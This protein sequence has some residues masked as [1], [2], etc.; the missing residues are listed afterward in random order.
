M[1]GEMNSW[2]I[3]LEAL[4]D[5]VLDVFKK[6][7]LKLSHIDYEG[8]PN[9]SRGLLEESS[10]AVRLAD[11]MCEH[12]GPDSAVEVAICVLEG[13]NQRDT[14]AQLKQKSQQALGSGTSAEHYRQKYR[15]HVARE[16]HTFKEMDACLGENVTLSS[17]YTKLVVVMNPLGRGEQEHE[18]LGLRERHAEVERE[19]TAFTVTVET[20]FQPDERGQT[21]QIVVLVGGAG[22]GKTVTARK[23]MLDWARGAI[24]AQFDYAFYISCR[25]INLSQEAD[26]LSLLDLISA[27][28]PCGKAPPEAILA[29]P[30]KLLFIIDGFDEL[31]FPCDQPKNKLCSDCGERKPV[32]IILSSLFQKTLLSQS[33][34]LI[35]TRP[36]ALQRL[37]LCLKEERYAEII[38]FSDAEK[39]EY[40][41]KFFRDEEKAIKAITFVKRNDTLF[42]MCLVPIM[43]WT[44][45]TV[46]EQELN[47]GKDLAQTSRTTT[48]L[49]M[50]YLSS[51]IK[52]GSDHLKQDMK[53][54][55]SRLCCMAADGIWKRKI[56]FHEKEIEVYGLNHPILLS[57]FLNESVLR[58]RMK[59]VSVY[60]FLHLSFQ[61]FFAAL[62]YAL[63]DDKETGILGKDIKEVLEKYS[64]YDT[65]WVLVVRFLFGLLNE[66]T[67]E[68]LVERTGCKISPRV[69]ED[70]LKWIQ[71]GQGTTSCS[72][73]VIH[74]LNVFHCLFEIQ[75]ETFVSNALEH[76][77]G[78][79]LKDCLLSQYDQMVLSF[80]V[81]RWTG[82]DS[83]HLEWCS[84]ALE[85]RENEFVP[86]PPY[87]S[88][89]N[90]PRSTSPPASLLCQ[91]LGNPRSKLRTVKLWCCQLTSSIC[92]DLAAVLGTSQSLRELDLGENELG[93]LGLQL[94]CEGLKHPSCQLQTLR[95]VRCQLTSTVCGDLAAVL[96]A[97]QSLRELNL[98]GNLLGDLG[99]QLLCEGLKHPSCQLQTLRLLS[100]KLSSTCYGDL[101]VVL[102]TNQ[103]LRELDLID[104]L[105]DPGLQLLCEELK[106]PSCQLQKL[107]LRWCQL[108]SACCGDLAAVLGTSQSLRELDIQGN[109]LED[110][111]LR[112]LCEGLKHPSCQLQMLR[113]VRCEL[114]SACCGDLATTLS[115]NQ[116]LRELDLGENEL[117]DPG[118]RLLCEGLKHPSC[119]LQ[120]LRLWHCQLTSTVCGDLAAVLGASQSLRELD[121]GENE[122]G[123]LGLQLLCEGLKHPSC[124]LQT[125]R[126]WH[127]QLTS[128]VCGD[129]AAVLGASQSLRELDLGGNELGDLGL[130]LLCE[131][132]KHP[133]CQLQTLRLWHCQ[134]TSTVCGDLAAVLGASQSLREL[135]LGGNELGD[136]GLQLLCEGLKHPSCQLQTLRL[137]SCLLTSACCGYLAMALST[138]LS[139]RDLDLSFNRLE[140]SGV[141]LLCE[142]LK[143]PDWQLQTLRLQGARTPSLKAL[144]IL[145]LQ[146]L[147]DS[148]SFQWK[149]CF[150]K[151]AL[152]LKETLQ[153]PRS[154]ESWTISLV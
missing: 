132:L 95:L 113:V 68:Y 27:C 50:L 135:D 61:E 74:N 78:I 136:L 108:D 20:L 32:E 75:E 120:M 18:V 96:G 79:V 122:L 62:F 137:R 21:P 126:L 88:H 94:L 42:A 84:V 73:G 117:G 130:Q 80:C 121:L 34:L 127:C 118:V 77:T 64:E 2:N 111:G 124:Q 153:R 31:R 51:L 104:D 45:C 12:Y 8:T 83:F 151:K 26:M 134:L 7:K 86:G 29:S 119:Q 10:D 154:V 24:Y 89:Q 33:S 46:L 28:C 145:T 140:D 41:H 9:L 36:T 129:L 19:D 30:E 133:S 99:L 142:K 5:L 17:R 15:D 23:I 112:L 109:E 93:D 44:I 40:F 65:N 102:S 3:L 114:A 13:I 57:L 141:Q 16:F 116:S 149:E 97:S 131:G 48:E 55:L 110:P 47:E 107:W 87:W 53:K 147:V 92:G 98:E 90:A 38:G 14:A 49:Y 82:L 76:F 146:V 63:E 66:E 150:L 143:R 148:V 115:I 123:D 54:F 152:M 39:D 37:G 35:T 106:H 25:E 85:D 72:G 81:K 59:C 58:N 56:L 103:S 139:M 69:K 52:C 101:A 138:N 71:I 105:R 70:L 11:C 4:D 125:L 144:E 1:A 6:F 43:C 100:C 67:G 128:T 22:I 91:A 60:S